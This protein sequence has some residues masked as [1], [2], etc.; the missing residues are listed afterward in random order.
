MSLVFL[1]H[2]LE[3]LCAHAPAGSLDSHAIEWIYPVGNL[4]GVFFVVITGCFLYRSLLERP[5][6]YGAFLRRRLTRIYSVFSVVLAFYVALSI[7][8]PSASKL[9]ADPV[10]RLIYLL[11]NLLLLPGVFA[12]TPIITVSWT[13]SYVVLYCLILPPLI[14]LTG[15]REWQ[16]SNRVGFLILVTASCAIASEWTHAY[17]L[18]LALLPVGALAFEALAWR[19]RHSSYGN[20]LESC[21]LALA[22][23]ALCVKYYLVY[24][25][26]VPIFACSQGLRQFTMSA[27]CLFLACFGLFSIHSPAAT[28]LSGRKLRWLGNIS[29]SY[30]MTHS[31]SI[32]TFMLLVPV[33]AVAKSAF[34]FW[35]MIP[36]CFIASLIPAVVLFRSVEAPAGGLARTERSRVPLRIGTP[37]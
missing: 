23:C 3:A 27:V 24:H 1:I 31:L 25:N 20:W 7:A 36:L 30:Y 28:L 11:E 22:A 32:K 26:R 29:Y 13:L 33:T 14:Q 12:I 34:G 15:M 10:E 4:A 5:V 16:T 8:F 9:P 6:H 18:R 17:P 37:A 35:A 21:A 2:L 19:K